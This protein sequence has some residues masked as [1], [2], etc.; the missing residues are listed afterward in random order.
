VAAVATFVAV[1][2]AAALATPDSSAR[3]WGGLVFDT[4]RL[5]DNAATADQS[6]R[7]MV[8]RLFT[9]TGGT[10]AWL[11]AAVVVAVLGC[12]RARAVAA[13]GN[14]L[15]GLAIA[16]LLSVLLSPVA[17]IH[18]LA[19]YLPVVVGAMAGDVRRRSAVAGAAVTTAVFA[20]TLPAWG[21]HLMPRSGVLHLLG[22]GLQDSFGIA[23]LMLVAVL[24]R[25]PR[26]GAT[27]AREG[28]PGRSVGGEPYNAVWSLEDGC[29]D[30]AATAAGQD[31]GASQPAP[32]GGHRTRRD[33]RR[34][35][36][37]PATQRPAGE[38]GSASRRG[39]L[40]HPL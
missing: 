34:R 10:L 39:R 30:D 26:A 27:V 18:H 3:Y 19:G 33:R 36:H 6:V 21:R 14:E 2:G 13:G 20:V 7:G 1:S 17:W 28:A 25:R 11:V 31:G 40:P 38:P 23:A 4:G 35:L 24:G 37:D 32:R 8:L 29:A 22:A 12:R 9:G 5:G 16:G 15:G